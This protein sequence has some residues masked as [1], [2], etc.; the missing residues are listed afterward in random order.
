MWIE[1]S[2]RESLFDITRLCQTVITRDGFKFLSTPNNHHDRFFFLHTFWAPVFDFNVGGAIYESR[3]YTLT[4]AILKVEVVCDVA[5][6]STSNILMTELCDL[7]YNQCI[8]NMCFYSFFY[9]SHG[10]DKGMQD[11]TL[12]GM[13]ETAFYALWSGSTLFAKVP[14]MGMLSKNGLI[15]TIMFLSFGTDRSGQTMQT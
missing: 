1:K 8:D 7:Q 11:K 12:S 9:L 2:V 3:S 10:L 5:M 13:Q 6:M 14:C 4:F 15:Y